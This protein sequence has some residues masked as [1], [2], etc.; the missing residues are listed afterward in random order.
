MQYQFIMILILGIIDKKT[1]YISIRKTTAQVV[2]YHYLNLE[3][4]MEYNSA[5]ICVLSSG[6]YGF[7]RIFRN[8]V[9]IYQCSLE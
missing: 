5:F 4:S 3:V 6:Y 7:F 1:W 2:A 8:A 9:G